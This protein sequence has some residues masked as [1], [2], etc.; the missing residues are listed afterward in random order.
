MRSLKKV[1]KVN[2]RGLRVGLWE[3]YD[4]DGRMWCK[5]MYKNDLMDGYWEYYH[6]NGKLLSRG[7]YVKSLRDGYWQEF[8]RRG[9]LSHIREYKD[10]SKI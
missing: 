6:D 2:K 10:G 4:A 3:F 9:V 8:N 1:N 5:G 7:N